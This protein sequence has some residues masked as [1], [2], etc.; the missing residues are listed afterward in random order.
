MLGNGS[1]TFTLLRGTVTWGIVNNLINLNLQDDNNLGKKGRPWSDSLVKLS[2]LPTAANPQCT[3]LPKAQAGPE[4]AGPLCFLFC[5]FNPDV[6]P[7]MYKHGL[8]L[9]NV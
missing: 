6:G 3:R 7:N 8:S 1:R 5:F 4:G 9:P 2:A